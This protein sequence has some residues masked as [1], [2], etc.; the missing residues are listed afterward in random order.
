MHNFLEAENA[1]MLEEYA[2]KVT[3]SERRVGYLMKLQCTGQTA[4]DA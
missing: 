1:Q 2:F 3:D 4:K